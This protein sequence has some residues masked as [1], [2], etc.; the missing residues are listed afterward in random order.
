MN[1][2]DFIKQSVIA[3]VGCSMPGWAFGKSAGEELSSGTEL[4]WGCLLHL[5]FN[6]WEEYISPHRPFRGYRP[7]LR[8]DEALWNDA[9]SA[10]A[11]AKVNTVVIDLGDAVAYE[12]HPEI[13]VKGA[14]TPH[15]LKSELSKIRTMG[16]QPIPK[17]NFSAGHDTW[18]KE[19]SRMVST[20]TYYRVCADLIREVSALFDTPPLFHLG[21]DE[22]TAEHQSHYQFVVMHGGMIS[23]FLWMRWKKTVRRRGSGR[24]ICCGGNRRLFSGRCPR[25]LCKAIGITAKSLIWNFLMSKRTWIWRSTD[26]LKYPREAIMLTTS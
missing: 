17:L 9:I 6:M 24:I 12:S 22:E 23:I 15:R 26:T 4:I 11:K 5:S 21:M 10:M 14:W 20:D 18:M 19:Y 2:R 16:I 3:G 13:A 1:R 8:M 25:P 7:Y